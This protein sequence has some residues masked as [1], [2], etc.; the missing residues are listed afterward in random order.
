[1]AMG[2]KLVVDENLYG[3][4]AEKND[5]IP[6]YIN[7]YIFEEMG[8]IFPSHWHEQFMLMCTLKKENCCFS[9][10]RKRL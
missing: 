6:V 3:Y 9:A 10:V 7:H 8:P 1:M 4:V 5:S 2:I